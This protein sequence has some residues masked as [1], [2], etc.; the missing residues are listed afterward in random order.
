MMLMRRLEFTSSEQRGSLRCYSL[1]VIDPEG[2][3][4]AVIGD[5]FATGSQSCAMTRESCQR[6]ASGNRSA[7]DQPRQCLGE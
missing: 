1:C 5:T 2:E 3:S 7:M 4:S 6:V